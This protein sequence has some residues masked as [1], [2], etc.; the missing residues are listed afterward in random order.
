MTP[1]DLKTLIAA[2]CLLI[3][4]WAYILLVELDFVGGILGGFGLTVILI[5]MKEM[6]ARQ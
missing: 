5:K 2:F 1:N 6:I 3:M 4:S